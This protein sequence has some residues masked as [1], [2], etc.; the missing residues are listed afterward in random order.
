[1]NPFQ[2]R[3]IEPDDERALLDAL[4]R[5]IERDVKPKASALEHADEYPA[6]MVATMKEMGLFGAT[7]G[8]E[9]GGLGLPVT[10]YAKIIERLSYAWMSLS[11]V[12]NS[13]LIM[14]AAVER[15]G[16]EAQKKSYLPKF[17]TGELR[18]GVA[19]TEPDCGTD[20]QGIRTVAK[21]EGNRD[22][23]VNG[24]KM[25]ITTPITAIASHSW[26]RPTPTPSRRT[27]A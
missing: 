15:F 4:E 17:A 8:A 2:D 14:A 19:L 24:A 13:H 11:G 5:F 25:W 10:T 27:R 6:E 3:R 26:P 22:Y 12:I 21:R 1:M 16:T 23:V 20:L 18:G 7:I 9:H